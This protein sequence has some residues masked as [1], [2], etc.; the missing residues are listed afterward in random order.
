MATA[1]IRDLRNAFPAV[2]KML[3][4]EGEVIITDRGRPRYRLTLIPTSK[5]ATRTE[6]KDYMARLRCHQPRAMSAAE[7]KA[8][9]DV[10][11]GNR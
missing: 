5:P 2:R 9:R 8:I 7:A 10:N 3:D 1:T 11:R 6:A 4:D